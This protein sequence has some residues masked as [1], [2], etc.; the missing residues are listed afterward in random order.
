MAASNGLE[1]PALKEMM[2]EEL[3]FQGLVDECRNRVQ[4]VT[5]AH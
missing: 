1:E 5:G 2:F 4:A 3:I